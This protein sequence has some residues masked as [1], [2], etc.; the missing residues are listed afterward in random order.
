MDVKRTPAAVEEFLFSRGQNLDDYFVK[1]TP[2]AETICYRNAEG[3]VVDLAIAD[4]EFAEVVS[5][6]MK[7]LGVE[8]IRSQ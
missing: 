4:P 5:S 7:E 2:V 3:E 6:R 8:I 1:Q